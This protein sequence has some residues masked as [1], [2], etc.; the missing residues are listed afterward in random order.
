MGIALVAAAKTD[1]GEKLTKTMN[2][3]AKLGLK[4]Q[5][6]SVA[7]IDWA[8]VR[9]SEGGWEQAYLWTTRKFD[10]LIL[11]ETASCGLGK[12]Q[13]SMAQGFLRASK[14]VGVVRNGKIL[15]VS[16]VVPWNN[17]DWANE[18]ARVEVL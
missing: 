4:N 6:K 7:D 5:L 9:D 14:P 18:F 12:G 3:L 13:A 1:M 16:R 15:Q 17:R 8:Q 11:I 2:D 10:A